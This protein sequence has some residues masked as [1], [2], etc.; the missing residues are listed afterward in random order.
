MPFRHTAV[1][2]L[3]HSVPLECI[4]AGDFELQRKSE[5]Y[6]YRHVYQCVHGHAH[7]LQTACGPRIVQIMLPSSRGAITILAMVVTVMART[8]SVRAILTITI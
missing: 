6:V 4:T 5:A 7:R 8:I 1:I 2:L 3:I